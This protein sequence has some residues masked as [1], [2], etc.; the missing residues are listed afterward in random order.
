MQ[1]VEAG[2]RGGVGGE[3][4]V[5]LSNEVAREGEGLVWDI[6]RGTEKTLGNGRK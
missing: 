4:D 3:G 6:V 1:G 2:L 5:D